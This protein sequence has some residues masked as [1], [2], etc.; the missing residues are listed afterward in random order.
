MYI[1]AELLRVFTFAPWRCSSSVFCSQVPCA[2]SVRRSTYGAV[3]P[4]LP[5]PR[6]CRIGVPVSNSRIQRTRGGRT[7]IASSRLSD[8]GRR[9]VELYR[10]LRHSNGVYSGALPYS[11]SLDRKFA[12]V[13]KKLSSYNSKTFIRLESSTELRDIANPF[14]MAFSILR[15][16]RTRLQRCK[17][18]TVR[19]ELHMRRRRGSPKICLYMRGLGGHPIWTNPGASRLPLRSSRITTRTTLGTLGNLRHRSRPC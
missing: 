18:T 5:V 10:P 16:S 1:L 6:T 7:R 3:S 15:Q 19:T 9:G 13:T 14:L 11:R 17:S 12:S 2:Q 4:P 8:C